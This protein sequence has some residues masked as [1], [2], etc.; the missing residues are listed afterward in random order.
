MS[1]AR[2]L[3]FHPTDALNRFYFAQL[4]AGTYCG[5]YR[6]PDD[7]RAQQESGGNGPNPDWAS[8]TPTRR[9]S[10][11]ERKRPR[12]TRAPKR[13]KLD[14]ITREEPPSMRRHVTERPAAA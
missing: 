11:T 2:T 14:D 8:S 1:P 13:F 9:P 5:G 12:K 10:P 6:K 7:I 3:T 4:L